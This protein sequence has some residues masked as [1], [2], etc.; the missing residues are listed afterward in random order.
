MMQQLD[1][2]KKGSVLMVSTE[3]FNGKFS[4]FSQGLTAFGVKDREGWGEGGGREA[5]AIYVYKCFKQNCLITIS[6][7]IHA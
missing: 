3:L 4:L 5:G 1:Q 2:L 6:F 7:F